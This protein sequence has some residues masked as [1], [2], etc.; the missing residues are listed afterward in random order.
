MLLLV[1]IL[2]KILEQGRYYGSYATLVDPSL[3]LKAQGQ[4]DLILDGQPHSR[5]KILGKYLQ[6]EIQCSV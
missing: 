4:Y 2:D 6:S 1:K 5:I 3:E